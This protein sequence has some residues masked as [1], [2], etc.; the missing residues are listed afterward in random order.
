MSCNYSNLVGMFY[1]QADRL[2]PRTALR[3]KS[4][5]LYCDLSWQ[6]YRRMVDHAAYGWLSLGIER[7]DRI[8]LLSE[9][10]FEWLVADLSILAA[11]AANVSIH[12]PLTASQVAYQLRDSGARWIVVSSAEQI[13]KVCEVQ[14][15]LPELEGVISFDALQ[16]ADPS[17]GLERAT[18]QRA[19]ASVH[20]EP[21][22]SAA[23]TAHP[24]RAAQGRMGEFGADPLRHFTWARLLMRGRQVAADFASKQRERE[25]LLGSNDLAAV[26]YTSGTTGEPKG[27]MLTHGNLL[28]NAI[29]TYQALPPDDDDVLLSWLPYSHIYARLCDHYLSILSGC[30]VAL[31]QG[32]EHLVTNLKEVPPTHMTG[33]PRF[34]EKVW[35]SVEKYPEEERPNQLKNIFGPRLRWLSAGGAPLPTHVA[36]GFWKCGIK[37][38]QGYGLTES[39]PVITFNTMKQNKIGTIGRPIPG[40]EVKIADDGEILA[41]GPNVM[42]GYWKKPQA[43]AEAIDADGWLHTG[44][45]GAIDDDGFVSITGRKKD[46]IVLSNG[47]KVAPALI[48]ALL[49]ADEYIDQAVVHGDQRRFL[50]ALIVPN[51]SRLAEWA[52]HWAVEAMDIEQLVGR[53][54]VERFFEERVQQCLACVSP[55][56]RVK[57]FVLLD[58]AFTLA[59]DEL[60]TTLKYRRQV[61][62]SKHQRAI[63]AL[64][65]EQA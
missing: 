12:A 3:Y 54:E 57:R 43:T 6:S 22:A 7:G 42:T 28:S 56:E 50:S 16:P 55:Q 27:V 61:I 47:K 4:W 20:S 18:D 26:M 17:H 41:R 51:F 46:L 10:R 14:S 45:L 62:F 64:Y 37:L 58:R 30:T 49:V 15:Q 48:E 63:D 5:G 60:T 8:A 13:A 32:F 19:A 38:L 21:S 24:A 23:E 35:E 39:S 9:N 33:V 65:S 53:P 1:G 29:A 36:E 2:G 44:D 34:Y 40:V 59:D 11:A 25:G 52:R 31:S